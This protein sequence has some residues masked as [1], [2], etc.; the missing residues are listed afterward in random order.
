MPTNEDLAFAQAAHPMNWYEVAKL[1]N[2][3]AHILH[4]SPQGQVIRRMQGGQQIVRRESNRPV[5]LLA[6][7]AMENLLKAYL[8]MENP[9]YIEGGRLARQL[10]NGHGLV[11]LQTAC[12]SVPA[13]KRSRFV[14]EVLEKGVNSWARYPCATAAERQ[15][16]EL[17]A[18]PEFWSAYTR[19]F[20]LYCLRLE[21]LLSKR[22]RGAY[23][24]WSRC[25]FR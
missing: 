13:P 10:M 9:R 4:D 5:F 1:M 19:V 25:A 18:T 8:V 16:D 17:A 23:G 24:E 12:K 21:K 7:F 11:K 6:A 20:E 22:R 15:S 2:E 3:S 14:F